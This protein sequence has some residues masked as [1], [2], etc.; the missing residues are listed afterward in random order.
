VLVLT[1]R[2]ISPCLNRSTLAVDEIL[3]NPKYKQREFEVEAE[4]ASFDPMGIVTRTIDVLAAAKHV[5]TDNVDASKQTVMH[6]KYYG[7]DCLSLW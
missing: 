6:S 1:L 5:P 7:V 2:P 4:M 3:T